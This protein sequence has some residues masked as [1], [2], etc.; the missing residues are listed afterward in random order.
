[1]NRISSNCDSIRVGS[2]IQLITGQKHDYNA[3]S[4]KEDGIYLEMSE[5]FI[6]APHD[7][8]Q[9]HVLDS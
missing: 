3:T 5:S 4:T 1:M 8:D 2:T 6:Y 7:I 9:Q